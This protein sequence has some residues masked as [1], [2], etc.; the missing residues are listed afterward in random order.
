VLAAIAQRAPK[1]LAAM[2][3]IR[4]EEEFLYPAIR[5]IVEAVD[6]VVLIDNLSDDRTPEIIRQLQAEFPHIVAAYVYP[7]RVA[8]YGAENAELSR[9]LRGRRSPQ[10]LANYYNWCLRR[11]AASHIMKWDADMVATAQF[12]Q[13]LT[14]FRSGPMQV[15]YISGINVHPART[16]TVVGTP[17]RVIAPYEDYEPRIFPKLFA[18]Y[19]NRARVYETLASPYANTDLAMRY[20]PMTYLHMKFCKHNYELNAS[21]DMVADRSILRHSGDALDQE[22]LDSLERIHGWALS[23]SP[24]AS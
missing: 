6:Q 20:T 5:S 18:S 13:A 19:D 4:N 17:D 7:H 3:R 15:M 24:A 14:L 21:P 12:A 23:A 1:T 9:T 8:R 2:V 10:L 11:C 22:A 16:H